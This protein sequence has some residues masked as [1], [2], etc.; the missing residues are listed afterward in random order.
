MLLICPHS[1]L[2]IY[3]LSG[4]I[5]CSKLI[6]FFPCARPGIR[7]FSK[8]IWYLLVK[9]GN[10]RPFGM[11]L[12]TYHCILGGVVETLVSRW[13]GPLRI[14]KGCSCLDLMNDNQINCNSFQN[15]TLRRNFKTRTSQVNLK[16]DPSKS[17]EYSRKSMFL[18][19][20]FNKG[21]GSS[22]AMKLKMLPWDTSHRQ[23]TKLLTR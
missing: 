3:I 19:S 17:A 21:R 23:N 13:I 11:L 15:L 6:L 9:N 20:C 10:Y 2:G 4:I 12:L 14:W 22:R 18:L 1:L 7:I 5:R 16:E 8:K